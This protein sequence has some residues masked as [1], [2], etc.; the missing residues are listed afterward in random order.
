MHGVSAT[1]DV[2]RAPIDT[3]TVT[4]EIGDEEP[5]S[6]LWLLG[7]LVRGLLA[8]G[9]NAYIW[10]RRRPRAVNERGRRTF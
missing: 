9:I 6:I 5:H 10:L 7:Q 2:P 4:C 1:E 3:I 8:R